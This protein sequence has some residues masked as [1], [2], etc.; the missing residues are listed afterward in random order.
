VSG[1]KGRAGRLPALTRAQAEEFLD[2]AAKGRSMA[3]MARR[4]GVTT[5]VLYKTLR[6]EHIRPYRGEQRL[7]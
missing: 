2:W 5:K 1:I 3:A 6:A 4:Y 7:A